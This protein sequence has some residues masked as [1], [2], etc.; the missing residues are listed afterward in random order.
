MEQVFL[1]WM[2][3]YAVGHK[4]L[5]AEHRQLVKIINEI[6]A[7]MEA[8]QISQQLRP[9]LKAL[10]FAAVA[11]FRHENSVLREIGDHTGR[12][13]EDQTDLILIA[14]DDDISGHLAEHARALII[15]KSII[16][17]FYSETHL[18]EQKLSHN[19]RYWFVEHATKYDAHLKAF[20]SAKAR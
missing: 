4:G 13:R 12:Y 3:E 6:H 5:D 9:L 11:H 16:R 19:L 10:E 2:E 15:L 20:F 18:T 14:N 17:A 7:A 8:G 1:A